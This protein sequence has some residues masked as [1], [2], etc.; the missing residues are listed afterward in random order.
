LNNNREWPK[1]ISI[2][3]ESS[4]VTVENSSGV[5]TF[6]MASPEAFLAVSQGYLRC[7]WDNKYVYSFTWLGRPII[8]LPDDALRLQELIFSLKP[9]VI[10]ETGI[11]H[12]GS[13]IFYASLCKL[14]GRG[15]VVAVEID[16]R[17]HNRAA[18][19]QD[20]LSSL[21][22]LIDGSSTAPETV[23]K[24]RSEV[25]SGE[26]V[27]VFLDSLHTRE[28]VLEEL[29][30]Y[31]PLVSV[32]SYIVAMDGI[33]QF[34]EGAPRA[35]DGWQQDNPAQAA[36]EFASMRTDFVLT[37]PPLP[38]NEGNVNSRVSYCPD[39]FLKRVV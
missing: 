27:L 35:K 15:R 3:L 22:T 30:L 34:L 14:M 4:S 17:P 23:A 12:G 33:M 37:E 31:T 5:Q 8:Q 2:D 9:D 25:K 28:H 19:E 20:P 36:R 13:A 32:G 29:S 16:L 18:I 7:G 26:T 39:A 6:P 11:A 21:I 1:R 24:V 38:F 10:V